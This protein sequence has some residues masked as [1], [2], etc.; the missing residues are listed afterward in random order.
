MQ[1]I[2]EMIINAIEKMQSQNN[3]MNH[4]PKVFASVVYGL[5]DNGYYKVPYNGMLYSVPNGTN[6]NLSLGQ[7]V[8][9]MIPKGGLHE[10]FIMSLNN[11]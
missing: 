1:K 2:N 3:K 10:M 4:S 8:W 6:I 9:V 11:K 7:K 5:C